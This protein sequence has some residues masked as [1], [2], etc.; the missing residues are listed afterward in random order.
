MYG[1]NSWIMP[2]PDDERKPVNAVG[3]PQKTSHT[4]TGLPE[5]RGEMT[6]YPSI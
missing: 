4:G 1:R 3:V 5:Y 2:G 6:R